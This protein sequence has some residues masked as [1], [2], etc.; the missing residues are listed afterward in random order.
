MIKKFTL[1]VFVCLFLQTITLQAQQDALYS[2]YMFNQLIYNPA[3]AGI[4]GGVSIN[5]F[6]RNQWIGMDDGPKTKTLSADMLMPDGKSA[7]GVYFIQDAIG[8]QKNTSFFINYDYW[9]P[10][11]ESNRLSFGIA[12]GLTQTILD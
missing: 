7:G 2:Q 12:G 1:S 9:L 10:L 8:P 5:G 4:K 6:M 3:Y 11:N